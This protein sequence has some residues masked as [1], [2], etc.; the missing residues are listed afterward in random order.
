MY[1]EELKNKIR[2]CIDGKSS[3]VYPRIFSAN[4]ELK[5]EIIDQVHFLDETESFNKFL[6]CVLNDISSS[7]LCEYCSEREVSFRSFSVGYLKCCSNKCNN[8]NLKHSGKAKTRAENAN[9]TKKIIGSDGLN[10]FQRNGQ[11]TRKTNI[12]N[13]NYKLIAMKRSATLSVI[14]S[15]GKTGFEKAGEKIKQTRLAK[16]GNHYSKAKRKGDLKHKN[17]C[18]DRLVMETEFYKVSLGLNRDEYI[19]NYNT[20][21]LINFKCLKCNKPFTSYQC[22]FNGCIYCDKKTNK[23]SKAEGFI[24]DIVETFTSN[25]VKANVRGIITPYELDLF[26][27]KSNLAIEID[28]LMFH[29]FGKHTSSMF[30]NHAVEAKGKKKHLTKTEMCEDKGIH[31][32]HIFENEILEKTKLNIWRSML[33]SRLGS[34]DRIFARKCKIVNVSSK[35]KN[36]FL[37]ENH[38]QGKDRSSVNLGLMYK[39]ELVSLMTFCKSRY[40]KKFQW[41]ISRFVTKKYH[42]VVGGAS[43][44]LSFFEKEYSPKSIITYADR[45]FSQ[46]NVYKQL[47]FEFSHNSSPNYFYFKLNENVLYSRL[48][49]QKH[50]LEKELESFNPLLTESENMYNNGYRRIWDSG[51]L[52]FIKEY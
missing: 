34:T 32:Y 5:A 27:D 1:S 10:G 11:L 9:E 21:M 39:D 2:E 40:S 30:D 14:D 42:T 13:G 47:G 35:D 48:K 23:I 37:D 6:Y 49:F 43:R 3:S 16:E 38:L 7:P 33:M 8:E 18:Y 28:G 31:L 52:V 50:K 51:N 20:Q 12:E 17:E 22:N 15:D 25:E 19:L 4:K 29:S 26:I 45:R 44:L 36:K 46:G 41:E 24:K